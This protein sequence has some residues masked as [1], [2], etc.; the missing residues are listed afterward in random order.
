MRLDPATIVVMSTVIGGALAMVLWAAYRSFPHEIKGL[1]EWAQGMGLLFLCA[2]VFAA[3]YIPGI[4]EPVSLLPGNA[5]YFCGIGLT[6]IGTELFYGR[7]PSWRAFHLV[8]VAG[9]LALAYYMLVEH[10]VEMRVAIASFCTLLFYLRLLHLVCKS[11]DRHLSSLIFGCLLLM[12]TTVVCIRGLMAATRTGQVDLAQPGVFVEV[13]MA[14]SNFITLMLTVSFLLLAAR[15]LQITLELR[16]TLDPLT[17]V[18]NRRGFADV[19]DR[20]RALLKREAGMMSLLSIDLDYFKA[21]NDRHGHAVGDKV[22]M[23]VARIIRKVLRSSDHLARFGG[24]EFVVLLPDTGL[25][26]A[27]AIAERIREALKKPKGGAERD[28]PCCTASMGVACQTG[29]A[30][31]L[32]DILIRSDRA[33][34]R[35][36]ER[37]RD[38][39]ELADPAPLRAVA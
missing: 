21:I 32:D 27:Q 39:I 11:G 36:K 10:D 38:R 31:D 2:F 29:G 33:L 15:R 34:Y 18:L 23:E 4:P 30:E 5:L 26:R 24:E 6:M 22:L 28:I 13:Y 14:A 12:Q 19:Y 25:E 9:V 37:G 8:W 7:R 20:E 35:A 1:K 16:S 3:R 17:Q